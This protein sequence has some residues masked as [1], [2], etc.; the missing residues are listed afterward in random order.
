MSKIDWRLPDFDYILDTFPGQNLENN[1]MIYRRFLWPNESVWLG[2]VPKSVLNIHSD[3]IILKTMIN[4]F[5]KQLW[6]VTYD[7]FNTTNKNLEAKDFTKLVWLTNEYF[8][9]GFKTYFSAHYNPRSSVHAIHP[10]GGRQIVYRLFDSSSD[11]KLFYFNTGGTEWPWL[12]V[13]EKLSY[14]QIIKLGYHI[15]FVAD[16]GSFIPHLFWNDS[17]QKVDTTCIGI[18]KFEPILKNSIANLRIKCNTELPS[19]LQ[20]FVVDTRFTVKLRF[21]NYNQIN[22]VKAIL[23]IL[24]KLPSNDV[25]QFIIKYV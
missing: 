21:L 16:H 24:N 20:S 13:C 17:L 4:Y 9:T 10:G 19:Y 6:N 18:N 2:P 1:R 23:L 22:L 8:T 7:R 12:E 11:I 14:E 3:E 15:N 25:D 5:K